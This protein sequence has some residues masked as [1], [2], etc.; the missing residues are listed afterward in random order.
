MDRPE[1]LIPIASTPAAPPPRGPWLQLSVPHGFEFNRHSLPIPHLPADLDG[2]KI[3]HLTDLHLRPFWSD[4]YDQL[5][6][7]ISDESPDLIL[8]TGDFVN[9]KRDHT[10][11][12]PF[13]HRFISQLQAPHGI[14]GVLGNHDQNTLPP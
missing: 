7:R 5:I 8:M 1:T 9:N 2:F 14:F 6:R 4:V 12:A 3:I 10:R 11:E 13:A